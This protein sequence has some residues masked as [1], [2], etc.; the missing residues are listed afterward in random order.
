LTH[1]DTNAVW[2]WGFL[3]QGIS[4]TALFQRW[5]DDIWASVPDTNL[6][7][8]RNGYNQKTF[9]Q[10]RKELEVTAATDDIASSASQ[11]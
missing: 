4:Y 1:D 10:I 2:N 9:D 8:S 7:Y 6:V 5:F 11:K 3:F